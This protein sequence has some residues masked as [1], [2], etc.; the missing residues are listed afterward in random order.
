ME[1]SPAVGKESPGPGTYSLGFHT[2][3]DSPKYSM[4]IKTP[5]PESVTTVRIVPGPGQYKVDTL[6][7]P[8]GRAF[9]SKFKNSGAPLISP[10]SLARFTQYS[11]LIKFEQ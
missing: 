8:K 1:A 6:A 9:Y 7:D 2:T 5:N 3:K 10:P 11:I 4:R